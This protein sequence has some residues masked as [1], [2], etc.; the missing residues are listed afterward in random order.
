MVKISGHRGYKAKEIE[1]SKT[2]IL[3]AIEEKLDYIEVDVRVT[4]DGN[5]VL[6]HDKDL[7]R[8]IKKK[9]SINRI[10]LEELKSY[11]F[12][13]GQQIITLQEC[14]DLI[15]GKIKAILDIKICDYA[16]KIID[17]IKKYNLEQDVIIQSISGKIINE[18]YEIDPNLTYG[19]Y[20]AYLG[21][22]FIPHKIF[23]PIFYKHLLKDYPVKYLSLDGP[24]MY[25]EFLD[26]A[27]ENNLK[28]ILGAM[29]LEK[30]LSKVRDW[31]VD[32]INANNPEEIRKLLKDMS[33]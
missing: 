10:T 23:T 20:K 15:K 13:D 24:F 16:S 25:K 5:L 18:F 6:S 29:K 32:I 33:I 17:L 11:H 26:I 1:N 14:F 7:K 4:S 12:E 21:K 28:I 3:R 22:E 30:Y 2:A 8:M 27:H 19:I 31:H 9:V